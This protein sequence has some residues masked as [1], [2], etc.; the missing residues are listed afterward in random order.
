M[1]EA[2]SRATTTT[3]NDGGRG[4]ERSENARFY[5]EHDAM[6]RSKIKIKKGA[7]A[8]DPNA[9]AAPAMYRKKPPAPKKKT[10]NAEEDV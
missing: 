3:A 10:K 2:S 5:V 7:T 1:N 4:P 9:A 8:N 6:L